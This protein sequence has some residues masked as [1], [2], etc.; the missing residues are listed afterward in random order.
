LF[1][2]DATPAE[3]VDPIASRYI[4]KKGPLGSKII[5]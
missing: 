2:R 1:V 4:I 5:I 3:L